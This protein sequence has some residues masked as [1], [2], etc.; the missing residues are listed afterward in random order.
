MLCSDGLVGVVSDEEIQGSPDQQRAHRRSDASP[1]ELARAGG[2][3][4]NITVIVAQ[5]DGEAVPVPTGERA[6]R[7]SRAVSRR[8]QAARAT[9][10]GS[11]YA[12]MSPTPSAR[13]VGTGGAVAP[14]V[15]SRLSI[16]SM[17]AVFALLVVGV[18]AGVLYQP[19]RGPTPPVIP[20]VNPQRSPPCRRAAD[21]DAGRDGAGPCRRAG[22]WQPPASAPGTC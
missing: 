21:T 7:V 10:V 17:A 16:I 8:R 13:D 5:V 3:P 4:D 20:P 2:G 11:E 9:H 12:F 22:W 15:S 1:I 18:L 14:P 6:R 19:H